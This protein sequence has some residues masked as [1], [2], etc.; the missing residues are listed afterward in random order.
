MNTITM[1]TVSDVIKEYIR[2]YMTEH[3]YIEDKDYYFGISDLNDELTVFYNDME[4]ATANSCLS[5]TVRGAVENGFYKFGRD[6]N[7]IKKFGD[8]F[9]LSS[10]A[11]RIPV[12]S[13]K[14][15]WTKDDGKYSCQINWM[16]AGVLE[17]AI[18]SYPERWALYKKYRDKNN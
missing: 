16:P 18:K 10:S 11:L 6:Y 7:M 12:Y 4:D 17:E 13:Y 5:R 1:A 15:T 9:S 2:N 8:E 14:A 3:L